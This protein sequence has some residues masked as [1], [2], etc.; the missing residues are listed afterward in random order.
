MVTLSRARGVFR[1]ATRGEV[2]ECRRLGTSRVVDAAKSS[3]LV[4]AARFRFVYRRAERCGGVWLYVS[5]VIAHRGFLRTA[6]ASVK[7]GWSDEE[8]RR[9]RGRVAP[10]RR[11]LA[12][13][14]GEERARG[15][16]ENR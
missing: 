1:C 4:A 6:L 11:L 9:R 12:L 5:L 8:R 13:G 2:V 14:A 16:F 10:R 3:R 7:N 15:D